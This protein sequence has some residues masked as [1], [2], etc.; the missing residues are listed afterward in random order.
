[1]ACK[2]TLSGESE[3]DSGRKDPKDMLMW[4]RSENLLFIGVHGLETLWNLTFWLPDSPIL[5]LDRQ[6]GS[7]VIDFKAMYTKDKRFSMG[8]S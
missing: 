6:S 8:T 5:R 7:T 1:M 4:E 3:V 2:H